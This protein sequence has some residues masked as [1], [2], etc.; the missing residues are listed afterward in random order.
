MRRGLL[1]CI[2][3]SVPMLEVTQPIRRLEQ[4]QPMQVTVAKPKRRRVRRYIA[5]ALILAYFFA[6]LRTNILFLGADSSLE[7]GSLG[8]TDT[9]LLTS[10]VPLKPY[11]GLLSIPR[12][13]WV[14]VPDV[15]EQRINTA[16]FYSEVN[17]AGSGSEAAMSA[18]Q[19]NFDV[20]VHYY[21]LIHMQG[22]VSVI[23]ALGGVDITLDAPT[24]GLPAGSYHLDGVQALAFVR[25][26]SIGDDF[27]R[28]AGTQTLIA[29]LLKKT[30]QPASWLALP[31]VIAT[32]AQ[33]VDTNIPLWQGPRLLFAL[34]RAPL[35]GLETR[36]ITREMVTPF[37]T[38]GGAQ[39][40]LPNWEAIK[41]LIRETFGR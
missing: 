20:P 26:R 35:F 14:T 21:A 18:I 10:V 24:G 36:T 31:Q 40:L 32:L 5:L 39:V 30:L 3:I 22:L 9:I 33:A 29:A 37:T 38:A 4:F 27:G 25:D 28:M 1:R 23:D 19:Q 2:P 34:V 8:R 12:D 16:Y 17:Q 15:G 13:L 41:P 6:P 11:V 7:R